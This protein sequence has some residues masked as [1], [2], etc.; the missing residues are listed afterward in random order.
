MKELLR[1][2]TDLSESALGSS[3]IIHT[4]FAQRKYVGFRCRYEYDVKALLVA[5][6]KAFVLVTYKLNASYEHVKDLSS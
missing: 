2:D 4:A 1:I 6:E 3:G 5:S